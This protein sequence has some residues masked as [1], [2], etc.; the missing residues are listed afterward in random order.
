LPLIVYCKVAVRVLDVL[1]VLVEKLQQLATP[2]F[3]SLS[4]SYLSL[5]SY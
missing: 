3:K 1:R 2:K 4:V 5:V